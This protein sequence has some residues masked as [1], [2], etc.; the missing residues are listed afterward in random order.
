M[1]VIGLAAALATAGVWS[2]SAPVQ[3]QASD[4]LALV[5]RIV[6]AINSGDAAAAAAVAGPNT[7]IV[8]D[9]VCFP[10]AC[11]G[12]EGAAK[13]AQAE[14]AGK[15]QLRV[16]SSQVSGNVATGLLQVTVP[17]QGGT[18]AVK[19]TYAFTAVAEGGRIAVFVALPVSGAPAEGAASSAASAAG[20]PAAT[21]DCFG[22]PLPY[23]TACVPPPGTTVQ[24]AGTPAR[25]GR[26]VNEPLRAG[27]ATPAHR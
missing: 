22:T 17:A 1:A 9:P 13:E 18:P 15:V 4:P 7:V 3:A 23:Y 11:T 27:T 2:V 20:T 14:V 25:G 10:A 12:S 5:Q 16:L 26:T 6:S 19:Q 24:Q 21:F 8:S